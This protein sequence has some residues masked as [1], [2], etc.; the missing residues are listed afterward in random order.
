MKDSID[1]VVREALAAHLAVDP[2]QIEPTHRLAADLAL[3]PLD[4]VLVACRLEE[5]EGVELPI[6]RLDAIDT[7]EDLSALLGLAR[8]SARRRR[9]T[10]EVEHRRRA[11]GPRRGLRAAAGD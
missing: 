1:E 11:P 10:F 3:Q 2:G 5:L 4:V 7:V 6:D 9:R 8:A